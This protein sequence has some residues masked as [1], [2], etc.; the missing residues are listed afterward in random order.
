MRTTLSHQNLILL[1]I[2]FSITII[3]NVSCSSNRERSPNFI[4]VSKSCNTTL[5]PKLCIKT[6]AKFAEKIKSSPK[7]LAMTAL[8]STFNATRT[9]SKVLRKMG[10]SPAVIECVE[11]VSD[12]LYELQRSV[13]RLGQSR[14]GPEFFLQIDDVQTWVSAALTDDDTCIDDFT[15]RRRTEVLARGF[16]LTIAR[17]ASISLTFINKYAS[18]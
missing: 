12:A 6:L 14:K 7:A 18:S 9:T 15:A 16:V 13:E 1:F 2:L 10:Q 11:V 3:S 17:L 5:Y 4:H 8:V